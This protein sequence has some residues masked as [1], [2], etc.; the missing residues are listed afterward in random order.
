MGNQAWDGNII[1]RF[2]SDPK[3]K[4]VEILILLRERNVKYAGE[5]QKG[6]QFSCKA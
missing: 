4:A 2:K 5:N 3:M 1:N 6:N